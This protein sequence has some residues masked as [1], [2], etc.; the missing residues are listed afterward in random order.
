MNSV[1]DGL[2]HL[3]RVRL[4]VSCGPSVVGIPLMELV[5]VKYRY[6]SRSEDHAPL[7]AR[8]RSQPECRGSV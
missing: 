6:V 5:T 4:Q 2:D 3:E 1:L 8:I 7:A